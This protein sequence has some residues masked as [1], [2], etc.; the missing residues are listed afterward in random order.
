MHRPRPHVL[1]RTCR[2]WPPW[3][4]CL[5]ACALVGCEGPRDERA[6]AAPT[7]PFLSLEETAPAIVEALRVGDIDALMSHHATGEDAEELLAY[8]P[9]EW[10]QDRA[11]KKEQE[12]ELLRQGIRTSRQR[13]RRQWRELLRRG[14]EAGLEWR[15]VRYK[16]RVLGIEGGLVSPEITKLF[17]TVEGKNKAFCFAAGTYRKLPRGY[18]CQEGVKWLGEEL[19]INKVERPPSGTIQPGTQKRIDELVPTD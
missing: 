11:Y 18:V 2:P 10:W 17:V 8:L 5:L 7:G 15:D 14:A 9:D 6:P 16:G 13:Y 19:G 3:A 1:R 12:L 4:L